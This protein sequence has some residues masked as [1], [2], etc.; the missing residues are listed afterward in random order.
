MYRIE[1]STRQIIAELGI[2]LF[3]ELND[4]FSIFR[5]EMLEAEGS[6]VTVARVILVVKVVMDLGICKKH[7]SRFCDEV[8]DWRLDNFG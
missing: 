6:A 5:H 8:G 1:F 4:F 7:I 2:P 3:N